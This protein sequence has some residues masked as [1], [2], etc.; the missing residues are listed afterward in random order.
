MLAMRVDGVARILVELADTLSEELDLDAFSALLV[1][2]TAQ[3][4]A[5]GT[6]AVLLAEPDG[7]LRPTAASQDHPPL[8]QAQATEGP[9]ADSVR[10]REPVIEID[11][12]RATERWPSF[13]PIA[14]MAGFRSVH[15]FPLR[16]GTD[17]VGVLD[18]LR[19]D[20]GRLTPPETQ[21]V[22]A[23][24]DV[25]TIG[26][27]QHRSRRRSQERSDQ[28]QGALDS[29]IVLEQAKGAL[30]Q[31]RRCTPDEAFEVMRDFA[32]RNHLRLV[33]VARTL[34]VAPDALPELTS[35]DSP[36]PPPAGPPAG[37]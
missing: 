5:D 8:L 3:V 11:L 10:D 32:R 35:P 22:Q 14:V 20:A 24:V 34:M 18:V 29:R 21:V 28:L 4:V 19:P 12:R 27:L 9:C 6:V 26:I 15:A 17:V 7:G 25:A 1:A 2:R 33:E 37:A 30:S 23:L 36:T 31:L 16:R 13:A